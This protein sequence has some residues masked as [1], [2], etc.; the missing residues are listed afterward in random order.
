MEELMARQIAVTLLLAASVAAAPTGAAAQASGTF[1]TLSYNVAGLLEPFSSGNPAANT[2]IISCLIRDYHLVQ[3]QEDFNYHAAH[4]DSCDDHPYRSPTSG[5]M[6]MGSGLNLLS[7]FPYMDFGRITWND[8]DGVDCLTPKG[9]TLA[10]TRLASGVYVDVYNL[11]AQA[12]TTEAALAAR[13][14]N[15]LHLA[16]YIENNSAGNAV[17]VMGD[18]NTRYTRSGDNIRELLKRGFRDVWVQSLRGGNVPAVGAA[19]LMACE[20]SATRAD[21]EVVDKVFYRDNGYVRL[22]ATGYQVEDQRFVDASG[23]D[24]SDH[25]PV[26]TSWSFSTASDRRLSE[27]SGGPHGLNFNDLALLPTNP[28][29]RALAIRTGAR[30]DQVAITLSNGYVH[31]HGGGGGTARSLALASN[32]SIQSVFLCS[33]SYN[34]LTRIF[35][36]RFTTSA[37]RTL[38]G[39]NTTGTCTTYAAPANWQ[40]VGF[41]GRS[42][43]DV[44]KLGVIYAPRSTGTAPAAPPYF[45]IVNRASG[46]C[47]DFWNVVMAPGTYVAQWPCNGGSWQKWNHDPTTGLIRSQQDPRFCLDNTGSFDDGANIV[48]WTCNGNAHQ[49]FD[50]DVPAGVIRMRTHPTQVVDAV[51]TAA[52]ND[53][54]TFSNWGGTNQRWNFVP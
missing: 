20:P 46:L 4:Y 51:G 44:D 36:V 40:I 10:R 13:R 29:P 17:I 16:G 19:A 27:Q 3:V 47:L 50:V 9:F 11:H 26:R 32:E 34:G 8:C 37:N 41:H 15:I 45:S 18:T 7:D 42:G 5:G 38:S 39:G 35:H 25:L 22:A 33:G 21:C 31:S 1:S 2:P 14:A 12:E 52:G 28:V 53:V 54:I 24:L 6:G 30:V 48:I 23:A 49:K 43:D